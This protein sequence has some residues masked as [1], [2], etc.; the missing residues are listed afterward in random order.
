VGRKTA[1]PSSVVQVFLG[2]TL[3]YL[4]AASNFCYHHKAHL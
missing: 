3:E 4:F 1:M 2:N